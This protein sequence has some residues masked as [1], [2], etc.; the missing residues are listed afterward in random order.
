MSTCT[1]TQPAPS[2]REVVSVPRGK[3]R[4]PGVPLVEAVAYAETV[5]RVQPLPLPQVP[6]TR[7]STT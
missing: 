5:R 4:S 6:A 2:R 1:D 3:V 7:R